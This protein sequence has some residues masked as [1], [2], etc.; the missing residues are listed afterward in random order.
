[1]GYRNNQKAVLLALD[2]AR[3]E[4]SFE[5]RRR[6]LAEHE[7]ERAL[8][9]ND[10]P[11]QPE[12]GLPRWAAITIFVALAVVCAVLGRV[13]PF[14]DWHREAGWYG[15]TCAGL[16]LVALALSLSYLV[17][18][19]RRRRLMAATATG[20]VFLLGLVGLVFGMIRTYHPCLGGVASLKGD[21]FMRLAILQEASSTLMIALPFVVLNV[22]LLAAGHWRLDREGPAPVS[23]GRPGGA[24][25]S[26]SGRWRAWAG[27]S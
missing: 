8:Q 21:L 1:M 18:P 9:G 7:L 11:Q 3:A 5:R 6:E 25:S 23:R 26:R 15:T 13:G 20:A 17:R 14:W 12:P 2:A 16:G 4:T 27:G 10:A 22:V 24:G 19:L